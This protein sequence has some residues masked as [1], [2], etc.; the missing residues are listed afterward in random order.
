MTKNMSVLK[1]SQAVLNIKFQKFKLDYTDAVCKEIGLLIHDID[2]MP[3]FFKRDDFINIA[4]GELDVEVIPEIIK[5]DD[6]MKSINSSIRKCY[7]EGEKYLKFFNT[8]SERNCIIECLTNFT[9]NMCNCSDPSQ[10]FVEQ[11]FCR[12]DNNAYCPSQA[13]LKFHTEDIEDKICGCIPTCDSISYRVKFFYK[14]ASDNDEV[15]I[16]VRLNSEDA[17]L[18]RRYQ[19]FTFT[20]IVSY[21]GGLLGL[22]AG[23]SV[24]SIVEIF[25]F[26]IIRVLVDAHRV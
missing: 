13:V 3:T 25:Y 17:I 12:R 8:Y 1:G 21:V 5:S 16:N 14:F 9:L 11:N 10:P 20:D 24:L 19:L 15:E 18:F 4:S 23:I 6:D 7:F 2:A 26:F 22:L